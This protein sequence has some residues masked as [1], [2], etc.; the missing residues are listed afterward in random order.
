[1]N[2]KEKLYKEEVL[3]NPEIVYLKRYDADWVYKYL[4]DLCKS[5][6]IEETYENLASF[7]P[8]LESDLE[9]IFLTGQEELP[10]DE[11]IDVGYIYDML[12]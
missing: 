7:V 5:C 9:G 4:K 12:S 10:P 6:E 2:I 8:T 3:D 1:M 11:G